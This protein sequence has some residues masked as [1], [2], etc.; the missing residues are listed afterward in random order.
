M[1]FR[2]GPISVEM[3]SANGVWGHPERITYN[4]TERVRPASPSVMRIQEQLD[5]GQKK[6]VPVIVTLS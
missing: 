5:E 6:H 3:E 4:M 1:T 2:K